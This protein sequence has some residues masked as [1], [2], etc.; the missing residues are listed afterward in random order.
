MLAHG[1]A[2]APAALADSR[3][4]AD[5]PSLNFYGVTGLVDMP[6]ALDQPDGQLSLTTAYFGGTLRNTLTFQMFPRVQGAFRYAGLYGLNYA[7]FDDYYDRSFDVSL[8]ILDE[9]RYLPAVKVGLQDFAG[10]GLYAAEY[11]VATK[12]LTPRL[13]VTGGLGWGRLGSYNSIGAPFG[14]RPGVNTGRGGTPGVDQWFR[15]PA[16]PFAGLEWQVNDRLTL[17]AEYSSDAYVLETGGGLNGLPSDPIMRRRSPFNFG[18]TYRAGKRGAFGLY[19]AYGSEVGLRYSLSLNPYD[20][21]QPILQ[22]PAPQPVF[23]RPPRGSNPQLWDASWQQVPGHERQLYAQLDE[24]M[25]PDGLTVQ[26]LTLREDWAELRVRNGRYTATAQA[27]GRTA[28]A[29]SWVLPASVETFRIVPVVAGLPASAVI[30]R[31]SDLEALENAPDGADQLL[32]LAGLE[33]AGPAD[34]GAFRAPELFPRLEWSIAPYLKSSYFDPDSP[35]RLQ[36][37]L[38]AKAQYEPAPGLLLSGSV[39]QALIGNIADST[40][41]NSSALQPVRSNFVLYERGDQPALEHLAGHA[42]FRPGKNLYGRI[43]A[44]YLERMFG[45]VQAEVLWK[46]VNSR[47]GIGADLAYVLQRDYSNQFTFQNYDV[48][49]GHVSAYYDIG[50]GFEAQLDVG[51]YLAGDTGATITLAREFNNGWR[52]GVFASFTNVSAQQFGEGSF[53]KGIFLKIPYTWFFGVPTRTAYSQVLRPVQRDGAARLASEFR[54]HDMVEEY[55]R[56]DL[57]ASW[58][59]VWR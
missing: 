55:H 36:F 30:L 54:L 57:N 44:G 19:Y 8:R 26:S 46:P 2:Q 5:R 18:L 1:L 50:R 23:P 48:L 11:I 22:E 9:G 34:P 53:D 27:I 35:I 45:G 21:P 3:L 37:G 58:G 32:A 24:L 17:M 29:M 38:R 47:L 13:R 7:N 6:S 25:A 52:A 28:R 51:R 49:T 43:S 20:P 15:G 59:R 10:T 42:F 12:T 31:R 14:P 41:F 4:Y 40:R 16:A 39:A 56:G 33:D